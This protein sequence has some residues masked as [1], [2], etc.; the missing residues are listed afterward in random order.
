[1][2]AKLFLLVVLIIL[3]AGARAGG[4]GSRPLFAESKDVLAVG[5]TGNVRSVMSAPDSAKAKD[6][7][8]I[9][10]S[11]KLH[12]FGYTQFRVQVFPGDTSKNSGA[13]LRRIRLGL[14]GAPGKEWTYLLQA[15]LAGSPRVL[16]AC[17]Q[18]S[19]LSFLSFRA[20]QFKIPFSRENIV[21]SSALD[22]IDRAQ[23]VEALVGRSG[24]VIGNQNGRDIGLQFGGSFPGH[25]STRLVEYAIGMFDGSGI[26]MPDKNNAKD[27]C[28]RVVIHPVPH[29]ELGGSYYDGFDVWGSPA[30]GRRRE[31]SGLEFEYRDRSFSAAGEFIAGTDGTTKREGW[32][33]QAAYFLI[34]DRLLICGR[35]DAYNPDKFSGYSLSTD[36]V[37]GATYVIF[38][39]MKF[40]ANYL[41]RTKQ[42]VN[43][44]SVIELQLQY[45]Y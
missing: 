43:A 2:R 40:Q 4:E 17:I 35:Y 8:S 12:L 41:L 30:I 29:L 21:S 18:Y 6:L 1:M 31:R 3:P 20:G 9:V 32:Y 28:G 16:D 19:P 37:L 15:E 10:S 24:D 11:K 38:G 13:D 5:D 22:F 27:I 26:N 45:G 33:L 39:Q 25:D 23:V 44:N 42:D 7:L 14:V 34:G 36:Y